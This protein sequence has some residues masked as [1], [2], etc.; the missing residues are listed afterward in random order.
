[1]IRRFMMIPAGNLVFSPWHPRETVFAFPGQKT[2][3]LAGRWSVHQTVV[4]ISISSR[5]G[6]SGGFFVARGVAALG[7]SGQAAATLAEGHEAHRAVE[8]TVVAVVRVAFHAACDHAGEF[9]QFLLFGVPRPERRRAGL[10]ADSQFP[11]D[12]F[13][14]G[15]GRFEVCE[16]FARELGFR[17]LLLPREADVTGAR[18]GVPTVVSRVTA[19]RAGGLTGCASVPGAGAGVPCACAG[20]H[21]RS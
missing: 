17:S 2:T 8:R 16:G 11:A 6:S 1:M 9:C 15:D 21:G 20:R 19:A 5:S 13:E 3:G 7:L 18:A 10:V 14:C 12:L 4:L